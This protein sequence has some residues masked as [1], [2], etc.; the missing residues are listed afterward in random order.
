LHFIEGNNVNDFVEK[1]SI[2]RSGTAIWKR[3][4]ARGWRT[5]IKR[6][7]LQ[8]LKTIHQIYLTNVGNGIFMYAI[9]K[10]SKQFTDLTSFTCIDN[11]I[12]DKYNWQANIS[13]E[14]RQ[15]GLICCV[16]C[17]YRLNIVYLLSQP[18]C[19][20]KLMD[21]NE[22]RRDFMFF[23]LVFCIKVL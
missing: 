1:M 20:S 19:H 11:T 21:T 16:S 6:W 12:P 4:Y 7:I 8:Y 9:Y 2:F 23:V 13:S 15:Y 5:R 10:K 14:D 3:N 22:R 18:Y 17:C